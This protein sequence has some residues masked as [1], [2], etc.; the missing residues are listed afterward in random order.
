MA[1]VEEG[2][3]CIKRLGRDAGSKAVIT[4]V[5]D[6]RFVNIVTAVRLKERKCNVNH[7]EFLAEKI[8]PSNKEQLYKTLEV[9]APK[10]EAEA[11]PKAAKAKK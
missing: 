11:E 2:R 3:V 4:K 6:A 10:P 1:L 9:E 7:L 5:V 8:D